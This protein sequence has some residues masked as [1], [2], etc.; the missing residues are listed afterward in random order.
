MLKRG[1]DALRRVSQRW[2]AYKIHATIIA[3]RVLAL[4]L[5]V[6]AL[7]FNMNE[8]ESGKYLPTRWAPSCRR[9]LICC[10]QLLLAGC[11]VLACVHLHRGSSPA[12]DASTMCRNRI[13][14]HAPLSQ[15]RYWAGGVVVTVSARPGY[16]CLF[17]PDV[18]RCVLRQREG[19]WS[20]WGIA[21]QLRH[22]YVFAAAS[23]GPRCRQLVVI[24]D[25]NASTIDA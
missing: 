1:R 2:G 9:K 8:L 14:A 6:L 11:D 22:V 18:L 15:D 16:G 10:N 17:V 5:R 4:Q 7:L 21:G 19:G 3:G 23:R 13:R 24:S 12:R 25:E 20:S